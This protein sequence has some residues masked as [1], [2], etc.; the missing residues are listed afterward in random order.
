MAKFSKDDSIADLQKF[1]DDVYGKSDDQHFSL[2]EL[3]GQQE[4]FSMRILKDIRKRDH[5]ALSSDIITALSWGLEVA[6][7]LH[8]DVGDV[9][10]Q[11]FPGVCSYCGKRPCSCTTR[12]LTSRAHIS[13]AAGMKKPRSLAKAQ[14]DL[15][16]IYPSAARTIESA[17]ML[18]AEEVG[19]FSEAIHQYY[20][21]HKEPELAKVKIELAD[22]VSCLFDVANSAHLQLAEIL[23]RDYAKNCNHC[24]N[25]PCTCDFKKVAFVI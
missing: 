15:E 1:L 16:A 25:I 22:F 11:R 24:H 12:H 5:E 19:E 17:G 6:N 4:R 9:L 21:S 18:L 20:L 14:E 10:W 23:A 2:F 7:R 8:I 3:V 13:P